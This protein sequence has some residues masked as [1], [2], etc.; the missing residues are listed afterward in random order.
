MYRI[1]E[2]LLMR[3]VLVLWGFVMI[4]KSMQHLLTWQQCERNKSRILSF[5]SLCTCY[6]DFLVHHLMIAWIFFC[7]FLIWSRSPITP[8][9]IWLQP[10]FGGGSLVPSLRLDLSRR[11]QFLSSAWGFLKINPYPSA[12]LYFSDPHSHWLLNICL[13][14]PSWQLP[15]GV[16]AVQRN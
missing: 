1:H 11:I 16:K 6:S 3:G 13:L 12:P 10:C 9:S 4:S 5:T 2:V 14:R 15:K 8:C 7:F